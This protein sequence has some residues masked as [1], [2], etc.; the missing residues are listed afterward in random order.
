M[1]RPDPLPLERRDDGRGDPGIGETVRRVEERDDRV[2]Q[3][4]LRVGEGH[5]HLPDQD[6][7]SRI[8]RD[9]QSMRGRQFRDVHERLP[10]EL[11]TEVGKHPLRHGRQGERVHPAILQIV[12]SFVGHGVGILQI[13]NRGEVGGDVEV[14]P[15][16][17][18]LGSVERFLLIEADPETMGIAIPTAGIEGDR[19]LDLRQSPLLSGTGVGETLI[20]GRNR[21]HRVLTGDHVCSP[22]GKTGTTEQGEDREKRAGGHHDGGKGGGLSYETASGGKSFK[23]QSSPDNF[24]PRILS[25]ISNP[26][27]TL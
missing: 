13:Q 19:P 3:G 23:K 17:S 9:L 4:L 5:F 12:E 7:S 1:L 6:Q 22:H 26:A 8:A 27:I 2:E 24:F 16:H 18:C 14:T 10:V 21:N 11:L 25:A 20:L 15:L